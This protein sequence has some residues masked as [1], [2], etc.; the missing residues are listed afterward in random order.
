MIE[1]RPRVP[2]AEQGDLIL[3]ELGKLGD[4]SRCI[5]PHSAATLLASLDGVARL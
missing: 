4:L 5:A 3:A 2:S 1:V